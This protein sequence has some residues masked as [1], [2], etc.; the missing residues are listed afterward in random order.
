MFYLRRA[1]LAISF[2]FFIGAG[3]Y[4]GKTTPSSPATF[5]GVFFFFK[6]KPVVVPINAKKRIAAGINCSRTIIA[7]MMIKIHRATPAS[8]RLIDLA[9]AGVEIKLIKPTMKPIVKTFF[10]FIILLSP[11][12]IVIPIDCISC[13]NTK[14]RINNL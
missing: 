2:Y 12:L 14:T 3:S 13:A 1:F 4:P 10:P 8:F 9:N 7:P 5:S 6:V 11:F